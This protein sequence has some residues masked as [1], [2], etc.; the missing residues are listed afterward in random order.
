MVVVEDLVYLAV[1]TVV[2]AFVAI[3]LYWAAHRLIS[4]V[5]GGFI[6]R[7]LLLVLEFLFMLLAISIFLAVVSH[8]YGFPLIFVLSLSIFLVGALALLLGARH[9]L[10][11]YFT[12]LIAIR[13]FDLKVGDYVEFDHI[14]GH[15]VAIEDTAIVIRDSQRDLVYIPYTKLVHSTFKRFRVEEGHEVRVHILIPHG[16]GLKK[17]KEEILKL[18]ETLGLENVRVDIGSMR[19]DGVVLAI[20]GIIRDPRREEE[21]KYAILDHIYSIVR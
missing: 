1:I 9:V 11:E 3:T 15:I 10:E 5:L 17:V 16:V 21:I 13:A 6:D 12:G 19:S 20:R 2:A 18:A 8:I 7:R 14:K 4:R